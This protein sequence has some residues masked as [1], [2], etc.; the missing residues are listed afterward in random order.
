MNT[1][2]NI[3]NPDFQVSEKRL[4]TYSAI[5]G[6]LVSAS[7][8]GFFLV[9]RAL[10]LEDML[11]LRS[12]NGLFLLAGLFILINHFRERDGKLE[13]LM[14]MRIGLRATA[15]A[16]IPFALF[17]FMVLT[18]NP[19]FMQYIQ[20]NAWCG[21]YMNAASASGMVLIEGFAS[22]FMMTYVL[23]MIYKRS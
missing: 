18:L 2:Q 13:Y 5:T 15:I 11:W 3:S 22:G 10:G 1:T 4:T 19:E 17:M 12:F 7:F 6:L 20:S 21:Q 8:I 23:M 9:M 16:M 14:G